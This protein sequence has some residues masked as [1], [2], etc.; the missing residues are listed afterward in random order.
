M[1]STMFSALVNA[2]SFVGTNYVFHILDKNGAEEELK[3]QNLAVEQ[4]AKAKELWSENEIK[5]KDEIAK[6]RQKLSD[7]NH[8]INSVNAALYQ[9]RKIQS[10]TFN[11]RKFSKEPELDDF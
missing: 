1:A 9:L 3:L 10:I 2:I 7:A 11:K 8:D 4:L 6:Y 5:R